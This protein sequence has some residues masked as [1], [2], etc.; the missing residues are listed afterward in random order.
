MIL[1]LKPVAIVEDFLLIL[2]PLLRE[3]EPSVSLGWIADPFDL[4]HLGEPAF[5]VRAARLVGENRVGIPILGVAPFARL[6]TGLVLEPAIWIGYLNPMI[7]VGYRLAFGG[8]G[9]ELA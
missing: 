8:R 2:R 3:K 4:E 9:M 6:R 1:A 5:Q 7:G